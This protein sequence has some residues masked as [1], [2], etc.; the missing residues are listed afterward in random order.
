MGLFTQDSEQNEYNYTSI[1]RLNQ[2]LK[3]FLEIAYSK[4]WRCFVLLLCLCDLFLPHLLME[5][6]KKLEPSRL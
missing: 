6:A 1:A 2:K 5:I 3:H 4:I